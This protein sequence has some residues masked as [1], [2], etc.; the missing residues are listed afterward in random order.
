MMI[1]CKKID[2][3]FSKRKVCDKDE[4]NAF[5]LIK[6]EKFNKNQEF[7]TIKSKTL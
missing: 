6:L 3:F 1:K 4:K 5:T 2:S 7:K